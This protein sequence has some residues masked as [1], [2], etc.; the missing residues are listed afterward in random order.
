VAFVGAGV[1]SKFCGKWMSMGASLLL[2]D[3]DNFFEMAKHPS[4]LLKQLS[5]S[6]IGPQE[7]V[8]FIEDIREESDRSAAIVLATFVE[9]SVAHA[10]LLQ[11]SSE[12]RW[13]KRVERAKF[14][15]KN[16]NCA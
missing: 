11:L 1:V 4:E 2:P 14:A 8:D 12:E 5:R 13:R 6:L 10:I 7:M 16:L 3:E 15:T 9:Q